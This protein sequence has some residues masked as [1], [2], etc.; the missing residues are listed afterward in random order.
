LP[1]LETIVI[2]TFAGLALSASPGP[3]ML[4]VL[5]RSVGQSH[6]A[7]LVSAAGL[8]VGG[9]VH[10]IAAALGLAALFSYLPAVFTAIKFA[11]AFYL[12]YLGIDMTRG[13]PDDQPSGPRK[14]RHMSLRRIFCQG[15]LV[16][17]LNPKT[18]LFFVAFLPQFVDQQLGSVGLQMVVLG[19]LVPLTAIPSDLIVALTGGGIAQRIARNQTMSQWL[20]WFA[21]AILIGL[22]LNIFIS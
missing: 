7:G 10:V 18:L 8:A 17:T 5:S 15:I 11:G 22:G 14:F 16:E 13:H 19:A 9:F 6:T 21:G 2:V 3:S 1:T 20:R 4:Y 12:I